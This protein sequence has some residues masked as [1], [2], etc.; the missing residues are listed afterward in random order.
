MLE[1]EFFKIK[2]ERQGINSWEYIILDIICSLHPLTLSKMIFSSYFG[3]SVLVY[4]FWTPPTPP[5]SYQFCT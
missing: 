5:P 1:L 2:Y 4:D 3:G